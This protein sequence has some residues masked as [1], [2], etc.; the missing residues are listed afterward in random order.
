MKRTG[1]PEGTLE[2]RHW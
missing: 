1:Q 2:P